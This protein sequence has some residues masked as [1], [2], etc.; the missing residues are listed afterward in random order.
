MVKSSN[1]SL[2]EKAWHY[3][4]YDNEEVA[5]IYLI[6]QQY[7]KIIFSDPIIIHP[8]DTTI[9]SNV[10]LQ[11]ENKL[12]C[13]NLGKLTTTFFAKHKNKNMWMKF[14]KM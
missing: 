6:C 11:V 8:T 12:C 1:L 3:K 13:S 14:P 5:Q 4:Y 2:G 10:T 7:T 9:V